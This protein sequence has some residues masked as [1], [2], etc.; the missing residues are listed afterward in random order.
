M[1]ISTYAE[2]TAAVNDWS[3]RAFTTSQTD[4]FI[5]LAEAQFNRELT[6]YSRE[7][8]T[9]WTTDSSGE[10]TLPDD[11]DGIVSVY[12]SG[13]VGGPISQVDWKALRQ[14]NQA[15][16]SGI[17]SAYAVSGTKF[18]TDIVA[19]DD[20]VVT[21]VQTLTALSGDNTT[22]WLLTAAPDAYLAMCR[23]K[24]EAFLGNLPEADAYKGE[25]FQVLEAVTRHSRL[26]RL[27]RATMT[28]R[29]ATP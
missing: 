13:I 23:S 18:K 15:G 14:R 9:T 4:N 2:L 17:A 16:V 8:T 6:H 27:G 22:N 28:I 11:F 24:A 3:D 25:A 7:T 12:V 29:G 20:Y 26:A 19:A 10:K 21:Y 5:A 1:A